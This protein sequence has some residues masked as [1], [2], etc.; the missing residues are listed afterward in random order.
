MSSSILLK[1]GWDLAQESQIGFIE[2]TYVPGSRIPFSFS[3]SADTLKQAW[4]LY[5]D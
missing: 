3:T 1:S 4:A 2:T 5:V